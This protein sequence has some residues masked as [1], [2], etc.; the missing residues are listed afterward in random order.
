MKKRLSTK[1]VLGIC[2]AAILVVGLL[3]VM[4]GNLSNGFQD[5]NPAD[6]DLK[7]VNEDNLYQQ[8]VFKEENGILKDANGVKGITVSLTE[9]NELK[10]NGTAEGDQRI[11]VGSITLKAGT[12]YI[13]DSS[14]AK[15]SQG[16]M[17]MTI[18]NEAGTALAESYVNADVIDGTTLTADTVVYVVLHIADDTSINN[19]TLRPI[20][21]E[22]ND[23]NNI[24]AFY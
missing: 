11:I 12:S 9:D 8:V 6:W 24:E 3:I 16:S 4:I 10:V 7:V 2:L 19:V 21:C 14:F 13:F 23:V 18:E 22:G 20:L 17:Y 5:M 15:G 1:A